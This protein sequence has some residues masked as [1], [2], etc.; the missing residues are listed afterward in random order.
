VLFACEMMVNWKTPRVPAIDSN[1]DVCGLL[2]TSMITSLLGTSQI[3]KFTFNST[4]CKF[5]TNY[6]LFCFSFS[7]VQHV[8]NIP[9]S[10]NQMK[11][12]EMIPMLQEKVNNRKHIF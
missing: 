11:V 10:I 6:I 1:G 4:K 7:T 2:T 3:F 8:N 12:K 9:D 5:V